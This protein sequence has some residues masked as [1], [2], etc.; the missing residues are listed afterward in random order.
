M[1]SAAKYT[2][3]ALSGAFDVVIVIQ[4]SPSFRKMR[5]TL[6]SSQVECF[7]FNYDG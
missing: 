5:A 3:A 1:I 4:T 7:I 6:T 2:V